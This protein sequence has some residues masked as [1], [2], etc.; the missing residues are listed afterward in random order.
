MKVLVTGA[1][2]NVG[3]YVVKALRDLNVEVIAA[4]TNPSKLKHLFDQTVEVV[5]FDFT[6]PS[7]FEGALKGVDRV[8]LMR[9]PHLGKAKDLYPFIDFMKHQS[10]KLVSFLSLMGIEKNTI[11]PHHKIEKYIEAS[12]IPFAHIRPGFFMQN[13]TG[14]HAYE[15]VNK[16]MIFIPAGKSKMSFI[17]ARDIG[18][19]VATVLSKPEAHQ[20]TAYTLTG[21]EALGYDEVAHILSRVTKRKICYAKPSFLSYRN[22]YIKDRKLDKAYVHVTIAL[23]LMTRMGTAKKVTSEFYQLTGK[24]PRSFEAFALEHI[25]AFT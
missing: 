13:L 24:H 4:G 15:I 11:P 18:Q 25:D 1:S 14:V 10:I 5:E 23:Y 3:Q 20:N 22:A 12:A 2:G 8:F 6:K 21:P 19:A 7:T 9:P 17:D 16:D